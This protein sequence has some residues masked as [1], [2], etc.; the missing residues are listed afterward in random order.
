MPA[1]S[2]PAAPP[3]RSTTNRAGLHGRT[4][5]HR[6]H[7]RCAERLRRY[8]SEF[9]STGR[10]L[11]GDGK[12]ARGAIRPH[13]YIDP[14]T[15]TGAP[16]PSPCGLH[17]GRFFRRQRNA[18]SAASMAGRKPKLENLERIAKAVA[19]PARAACFRSG[20][21]RPTCQLQNARGRHAT[22]VGPNF[23]T[24]N[25]YASYRKGYWFTGTDPITTDVCATGWCQIVTAFCL[26][27]DVEGTGIF[28]SSE[29]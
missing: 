11:S 13:R 22:I 5:R 25:S 8:P 6:V 4:N 20:D 19:A 9:C 23:A 2:S 1:E 7:P 3:E 21:S 14:A 26:N 29:D 27:E 17:V 18:R 16:A 15:E 24:T 10:A 28:N 12:P